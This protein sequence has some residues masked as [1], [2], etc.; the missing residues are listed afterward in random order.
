MQ[1]GVFRVIKCTIPL[2]EDKTAKLNEY[3]HITER[4]NIQI[5]MKGKEAYEHYSR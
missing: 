5:F 3:V 4:S 2:E 1:P